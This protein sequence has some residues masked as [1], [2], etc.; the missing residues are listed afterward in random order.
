MKKKSI[1]FQKKSTLSIDIP[2]KVEYNRLA[3][4]GDTMQISLKA[5]RVT[6]NYLNRVSLTS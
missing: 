3:M 1:F 4:G 2:L 6:Q 5:A